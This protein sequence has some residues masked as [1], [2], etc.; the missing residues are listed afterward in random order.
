V[1]PERHWF[2]HYASV[3]WP[4]LDQSQLDWERGITAVQHW[5]T[6][7]VGGHLDTWAWDDGRVPYHLGVSFR[8]DQD[9]LMFVLRWS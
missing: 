6:D 1:L 9:R 3:P 2:I 4:Y 5:L 7:Q 8:W